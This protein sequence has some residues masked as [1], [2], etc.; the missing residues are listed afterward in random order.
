MFIT[1]MAIDQHLSYGFID[2]AVA[3]SKRISL[4]SKHLTPIITVRIKSGIR[5][6]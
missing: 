5:G 1:K 2:L 4:V 3:K 6:L